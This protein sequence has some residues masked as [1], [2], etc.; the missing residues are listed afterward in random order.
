MVL[1]INSKVPYGKVFDF[2]TLGRI[3]ELDPVI[4]STA[5]WKC[6]GV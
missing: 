1:E 2:P 3:D 4:D 5:T 6:G